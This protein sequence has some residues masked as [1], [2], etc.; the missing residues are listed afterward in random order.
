MSHSVSKQH[1]SA[2]DQIKKWANKETKTS[3][4]LESLPMLAKRI[5]LDTHQPSGNP[6]PPGH[7][8][9]Q[10]NKGSFYTQ[11]VPAGS[12]SRGEDVT[13]CVNDINQLHVTFSC[14][15]SKVWLPMFG[16]FSVRTDVHACDEGTWGL[17]GHHKRVCTESWLQEKNPLPHRAIEPG[18]AACRFHT[19]PT[20]LPPHQLYA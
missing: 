1:T 16:I 8:E 19:L 7:T 5:W 15:Q 13:V 10:L 9:K 11:T 6:T 12:L 18:S 17:H 2:T 20:E 14:V 4:K 3:F